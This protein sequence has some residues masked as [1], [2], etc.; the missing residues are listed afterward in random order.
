MDKLCLHEIGP[1]LQN[2]RNLGFF[3]EK[4]KITQSSRSTCAEME[5]KG[6]EKN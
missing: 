6:R 3:A 5:K 2:V 1:E 4:I